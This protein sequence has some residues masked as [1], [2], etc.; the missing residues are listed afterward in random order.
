[1]DFVELGDVAQGDEMPGRPV[2]PWLATTPD[3]HYPSLS[4]EISVDVAVIGGGITGIA[5]AYPLKQ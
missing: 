1:M 4:G 5:A 3:T 2:S